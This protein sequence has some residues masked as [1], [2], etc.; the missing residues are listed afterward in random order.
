MTLTSYQCLLHLPFISSE[1]CVTDEFKHVF[2]VSV[3]I[4]IYL[5]P[6]RIVTSHPVL[7]L[8][9]YVAHF[10]LQPFLC[11]SQMSNTSCVF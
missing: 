3:M 6:T 2:R 7:D 4:N 8:K 9:Y 10:L 1:A 5:L 11:F